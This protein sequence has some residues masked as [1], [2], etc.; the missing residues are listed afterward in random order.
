MGN[1]ASLEHLNPPRI[2]DQP[3]F[4]QTQYQYSASNAIKGR[5]FTLGASFY[6]RQPQATQI[7]LDSSNLHEPETHRTTTSLRPRKI[8]IQALLRTRNRRMPEPAED[9]ANFQTATSLK[10]EDTM[11]VITRQMES[12]PNIYFTKRNLQQRAQMFA[13]HRD[14]GIALISEP[15]MN[16]CLLPSFSPERAEYIK[17]KRNP[18]SLI[19][20]ICGETVSSVVPHNKSRFKSQMS[21]LLEP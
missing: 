16:P 21:H 4:H 10:K 18:G 1:I 15:I 14:S 13:T 17:L 19:P 20:K 6:S 11:Q 12:N 5:E 7:T 2:I 3:H 9:K 8:K